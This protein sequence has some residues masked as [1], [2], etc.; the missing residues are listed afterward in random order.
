MRQ[1][2]AI[3]IGNIH[4]IAFSDKNMTFLIQH[5]FPSK[6]WSSKFSTF[7]LMIFAVQWWKIWNLSRLE[8]LS[9]SSLQFHVVT[10]GHWSHDLCFRRDVFNLFFVATVDFLAIGKLSRVHLFI[11]IFF[12]LLKKKR[13]MHQKYIYF[14]LSG[15]PLDF[16]FFCQGWWW[17]LFSFSLPSPFLVG[18]C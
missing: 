15:L 17:L 13:K 1:C 5:N 14:D 3:L 11:V 12:Q 2:V 10:K 16:L 18:S 8:K 4:L 9:S 7:F 6:L